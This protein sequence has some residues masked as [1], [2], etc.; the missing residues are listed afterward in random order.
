MKFVRYEYE[1]IIR[2]GK[3]VD[4]FI[5][6]QADGPTFPLPLEEVVLHIPIEPTKIIMVGLNY[7]TRQ[8]NGLCCAT[9]GRTH[10]FH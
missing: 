2:K 6:P 9:T 7:A 3:L 4:G 5:Y 8:R 1:G 10:H